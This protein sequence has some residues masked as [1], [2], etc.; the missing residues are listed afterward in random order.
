M[1]EP[2]PE[3]KPSR[4]TSRAKAKSKSTA[5]TKKGV[6]DNPEL[7]FPVEETSFGQGILDEPVAT[8]ITD[9]VAPVTETMVEEQLKPIPV[10]EPA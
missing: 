1:S 9:E 8:T 10:A 3:S 2:I 6:V 5:S 4:P 7:P